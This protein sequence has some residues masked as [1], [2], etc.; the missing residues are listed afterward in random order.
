MDTTK[1]QDLARLV[2][3]ALV[4]V[5]NPSYIP[6]ALR[7][8]QQNKIESIQEKLVATKRS[9]DQ[10]KD[11]AVTVGE[12]KSAVA[13]GKPL[14][15]YRLRSD[16]LAK[17]PGLEPHPHMI[18]ATKEV[19]AKERDLVTAVAAETPAATD[20]PQADRI[21]KIPSASEGGQAPV[22]ANQVAAVL[23]KGAVYGI[24]VKTG[25]PLWR[26]HLGTET[27]FHPIRVDK[28]PAA[29]ILVADVKQKELLRLAAPTGKVKWRLP[30]GDAF[31][32]PVLAGE[33][34]FVTT[35]GGEVW[36]IDVEGGGSTRRA[37][38]PQT[39][40]VAPAIGARNTMLY[41]P[42]AESTLFA[43]G[44]DLGCRETT[45]LA[46]RKGASQ[47][48]PLAA[49]GQVFV[50]ENGPDFALIHA[51]SA[52]KDGV[53]LKRV[54]EPFRLRGRIITPGVAARNRVV[55]ATDLG[56]FIVF[57]IDFTNETQ[58]IAVVGRGVATEKSSVAPF[59]LTDGEQLWLASRRL[60][61]YEIQG[62]LQQT[63]RKWSMFANE[64]FVAPL[65]L[66]GETLLHT[67]QRSGTDSIVIEAAKATDGGKIWTL[68]LGSPMAGLFAPDGERVVAVSR[69]GR[70]FDWRFDERGGG[71]LAAGALAAEPVY[72]GRGTLLGED[73]ALFQTQKPGRLISQ[74]L[75]SA[76][77][78]PPQVAAVGTSF[79]S[80]WQQPVEFAAGVLAP[81]KEGAVTLLHPD[82]KEAVL[83][84]LPSLTPNKP[85]QWH[86]P[87]VVGDERRAFVIAS[88]DGRLFRVAVKDKPRPHLSPL[89]ESKLTDRIAAP[90]AA[91]GDALVAVVR[92]EEA[93]VVLIIDAATLKTVEEIPQPG[94]VVWGPEACGDAVAIGVAPGRLICV[95]SAKKVRWAIDTAGERLAPPTAVADEWLAVAANGEV[96]RISAADGEVRGRVAAG[97]PVGPSVLVRG[98]RLIAAAA[99]GTLL[100]L[101][102]GSG[103]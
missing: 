33:K 62:S 28:Q 96:L 56:E 32:G 19:A 61:K 55:F 68:E 27:V 30:I 69:A 93:D 72:V 2:E 6:S 102:F 103:T 13:A 95:D 29:D 71:E 75:K 52:N 94:R 77:S 24:A 45:Y 49:L 46:H 97:E 60:D 12:M 14:D 84:F 40:Q 50:V 70:K 34:V 15:A 88:D 22:E 41:Q 51:L 42:G 31:F 1:R 26:R 65:Q 90:L 78:S 17:F 74:S 59:V 8:G 98:T 80:T 9:I 100:V 43:L 101:P 73:T 10:D 86:R 48:P 11:L 99:D 57:E 54:V 35:A 81:N 82:G 76:A 25:R 16:I 85:L 47:V 63:A 87:A 89:L 39:A 18:E 21:Q 92:R 36:E 44:V 4:L 91:A 64:S 79:G 23:I 83:P 3:E 37:K 67:R 66:F 53:S 58:P 5:N 38:L 7:S 20:D